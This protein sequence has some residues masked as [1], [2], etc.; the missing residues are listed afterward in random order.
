M[1]DKLNF[2]LDMNRLGIMQE[3][4]GVDETKK[5]LIIKCRHISPHPV[6]N[7]DNTGELGKS[8]EMNGNDED[9]VSANS[10]IQLNSRSLFKFPF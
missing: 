5:K 4:K 1:E 3:V 6:L 10:K 8:K 2:T 9:I 7:G